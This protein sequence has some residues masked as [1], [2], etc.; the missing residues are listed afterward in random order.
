MK[1]L[2]LCFEESDWNAKYNATIDIIV[3]N[4]KALFLRN[5]VSKSNFLSFC[6]LKSAKHSREVPPLETLHTYH[7]DK[8]WNVLKTL[9]TLTIEGY[10]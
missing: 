10:S 5:L 9:K 1:H 6:S 2:E 8:N 4:I 3:P 7:W